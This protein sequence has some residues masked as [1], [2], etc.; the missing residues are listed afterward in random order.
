MFLTGSPADQNSTTIKLFKAVPTQIS[1]I[2]SVGLEKTII[3]ILWV[4][5]N[6]KNTKKYIFRGGG[7]GGRFGLLN[8]YPEIFYIISAFSTF[9]SEV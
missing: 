8:I 9:A 7:V 1:L 3:D 6:P 5:G 4:I 2:R